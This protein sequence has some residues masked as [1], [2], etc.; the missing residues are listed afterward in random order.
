MAP[1]YGMELM[2]IVDIA[3]QNIKAIG[4]RNRAV[5]GNYRLAARQQLATDCV[6]DQA[7]GS[8]NKSM[9]SHHAT[10]LFQNMDVDRLAKPFD[11][12]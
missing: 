10:P 12:E 1:G 7:C 9:A 3:F 6:A 11:Q 8:R 4:M 5:N 2:D